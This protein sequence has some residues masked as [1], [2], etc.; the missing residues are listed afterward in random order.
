V[1]AISNLDDAGVPATVARSISGHRTPSLHARYQLT[2]E[3]TQ[4]DALDRAE[5]R[6][7]ERAQRS[8]HFHNH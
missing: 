5:E 8:Q 1:S 3:S 6:T 4:A 2:A 7:A